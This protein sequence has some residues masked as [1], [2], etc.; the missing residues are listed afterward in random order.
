MTLP[1]VRPGAGFR[2]LALLA[3]LTILGEGGPAAQNSRGEP[4]PPYPEIRLLQSQDRI[5]KQHLEDLAL[6]YVQQSAGNPLPPLGLSVYRVRETDDFFSLAARFNLPQ[7][8]LSTLN[9]L[10]SP[11]DLRPGSY[12]LV[13]NQ[14][15]I[16]FPREAGT[17]LER[18][19]QASRTLSEDQGQRISLVRE[20]REETFLFMPALRWTA[21]ERAYFLGIL[22]R[23]PLPGSRITSW[24]GQ[25]VSPISG[26]VHFH[27]GL[28]MAAPEGTPVYPAREG[29]VTE[30]GYSPVLGNYV[31]VAH[32]GGYQTT[33]GHLKKIFVELNQ[34]ITSSIILGEVGSTGMSTGPHLHFEF[35][36]NGEPVDP[37][38]LIPGVNG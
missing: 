29:R 34:Y 23:H 38:T 27:P 17:E 9:R 13:P 16:F 4:E 30:A 20:G 11:E 2:I 21:M 8:T 32:S 3:V 18:F 1:A 6:A 37:R 31:V 5:L 22:F 25:R 19:S 35:R 14:P 12:L 26:Q 33:Y 36:R 10:S 28:D 15:G 7:E 24:F